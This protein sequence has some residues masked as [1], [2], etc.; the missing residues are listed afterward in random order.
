VTVAVGIKVMDETALDDEEEV[1][2][3]DVLVEKTVEV[4]G[5]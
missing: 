3:E 1:R 2:V 4:C 5:G